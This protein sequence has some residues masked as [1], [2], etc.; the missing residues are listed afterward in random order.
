MC[1]ARLHLALCII[2]RPLIAVVAL[3][4]GRQIFTYDNSSGV[5]SIPAADGSGPLCVDAGSFANCSMTPYS[6]YPYCNSSLPAATR[7]ADLASRLNVADYA[8]LLYRE[9]Q[10]DGPAVWA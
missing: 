9:N 6:G 2:I 10:G 5:V 1:D 3:I 4:R 8:N 7:A